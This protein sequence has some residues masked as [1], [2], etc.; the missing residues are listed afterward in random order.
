MDLIFVPHNNFFLKFL[1]IMAFI[2]WVIS[3]LFVYRV[4]SLLAFSNYLTVWQKRICCKIWFIYWTGQKE[5][6]DTKVRPADSDVLSAYLCLQ[7]TN[8]MERS[9]CWEVDTLTVDKKLRL[10][11]MMLSTMFTTGCYKTLFWVNWIQSLLQCSVSVSILFSHLCPYLHTGF[12]CSRYSH[13][14][15]A[16]FRIQKYLLHDILISTSLSWS[17]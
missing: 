3:T 2:L 10:W 17:R 12:V 1:L 11:T 4:S 13:Q 6:I 15:C 16:C 14:M 5:W 7:H 9:T 8:S